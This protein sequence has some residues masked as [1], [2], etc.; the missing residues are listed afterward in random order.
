MKFQN[1]QITELIFTVFI[2]R[3]LLG[4]SEEEENKVT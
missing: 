3:V 2:F 4:K 1:Q